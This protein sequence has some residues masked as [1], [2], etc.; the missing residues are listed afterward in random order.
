MNKRAVLFVFTLLIII[1]TGCGIPFQKKLDMY[2]QAEQYKEAD[3]LIEAEKTSPKEGIYNGKN[4]LLYFFD[5][6]AVL[7]MVKDYAGSTAALAKAD[8][9]IDAL[10]TK[11]IL[12]EAE[13]LLSDENAL[14]YRGEDFERVMV[15]ILESLNFMYAGDFN[16]ARVEVK[17]IDRKL[18]LFSDEYGDKCIY[19]EDAFARY[20]SGFAYEALGEM[21]NAFIDYKKSLKAYEKYASVYGTAVPEFIKSDVL[22][23]AGAVK[24]TEAI[25]EYEAAWGE[26]PAYTPYKELK[27]K[28]D[29]MLVFYNGMSPVK[30]DSDSW[31]KYRDRGAAI[32]EAVAEVDG[33]QFKSQA[34]Q[35]VSIMAAKNLDNRTGLI[36]AKKAASNLVK[37]FFA[38]LTK[39]KPE[40]EKAD[41][42]CWKTIPSRFDIIRMELAPGKKEIKV[43]LSPVDGEPRDVKMSID[44]KTGEKKVLP[45]F[46]YSGTIMPPLVENK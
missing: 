25:A 15:N 40:K 36:L 33:S 29:V 5:K 6:G 32:T 43:H 16:G 24:N 9:K 34:A 39:S 42:R 27:N 37:G 17:K 28:G 12:N 22:R 3:A 38:A 46:V 26:K 41:I 44:I 2:L 23:A 4:E 11:S 7:Q 10:Y 35:E 18:N 14:E 19:T 45:V 30:Y 31:P 21:D 13:S 1:L 20:L 8:D